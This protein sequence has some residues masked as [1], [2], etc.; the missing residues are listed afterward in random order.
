[1]KTSAE[2]LAA[3]REKLGNVS[4]YR[5]AERWNVTRQYISQVENGRKKLSAPLCDRA[6]EILEIEPAIVRMIVDAES[7]KMSHVR[8]SYYRVLKQAGVAVMVMCGAGLQS[9][10][11]H[12]MVAH[13]DA[14]II[15]IMRNYIDTRALARSS[16]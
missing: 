11:A 6:A 10:T 4:A 5:V 7:A 2:I 14:S 16:P 9:P 13:D 8:E 1:M 15:Y 3:V 12:A